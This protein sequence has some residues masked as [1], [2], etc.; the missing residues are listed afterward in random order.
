MIEELPSGWIIASLREL[1]IPK[2]GK[3]PNSLINTLA[4]GYVPYLDIYAIEKGTPRQF[5]D[6]LSSRLA[7]E[8]DL[9]VVWDGARSGWVGTGT[10]GAIGSTIMG[11]TPKLLNPEYLRYYLASQFHAINTNTRGTGIPHV[12]PDVFWNIQVPVAPANEQRRLV[13]KLD[14]VFS[15]TRDCVERLERTPSI[16]KRFRQSAL[17]AACSGRL[18]ADWRSH[19]SNDGVE[20]RLRPFDNLPVIPDSWNWSRVGSICK[21]IVDCPHSTPKWTDV[22]KL[23][24]RTKNFR[25]G[26]LDLSAVRYVSDETFIQRIE[27]L[28]PQSG[29]VLYSR[30]GGILGIACQIPTNVELC[31]GQRMMLFRTGDTYSS[32]FLMHWL[33]SPYILERVRELTSGSAS[34]HLNVKD[35]KAF[36]APLPPKAEQE[37]I[38]RR[39]ESLFTLAD[40]LEARYKK[41]KAYVDK[42]TQSILAKAFRGELVPQDPNDEPAEELLRKFR[43]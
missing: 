38:V 26:F 3:K 4:K 36:P 9:F 15:K 1:V 32:A 24:V 30:E 31:L 41:G 33:N 20:L 6:V 28:R 35:I 16:L 27:R 19:N 40:Q 8:G 21:K 25:P 10:S 39:V 13:A 18:T 22:G 7:N 29:D 2:K 11:L 14:D 43:I 42:L 5:A 34:P 37:E 17:A 12:D 23:C